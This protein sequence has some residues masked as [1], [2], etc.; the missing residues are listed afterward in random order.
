MFK[1]R[2][3]AGAGDLKTDASQ[4]SN[5]TINSARSAIER[6]LAQERKIKA[7]KK[8]KKA[9]SELNVRDL[10]LLTTNKVR[11]CKSQ[12]AKQLSAPKLFYLLVTVV[13]FQRQLHCH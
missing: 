2:K 5:T 10:L 13:D 7:E 6:I 8:K 11:L 12:R 3:N 1:A 4:S 9:L